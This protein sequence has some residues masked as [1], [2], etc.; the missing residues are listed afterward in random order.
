MKEKIQSSLPDI[1]RSILIDAPIQKVWNAIS[2]TE[3]LALWLMPNDFKL[4][5]DYEFTF[6]SEPKRGWNGIINCKVTEITPPT[7]LAFTWCGNS[8]EQYVSFELEEVEQD[9]TSFLLTHSGWTEENKMIR[10]IMYEGWG[11]LAEDL[12]NKIGEKN[13]KYLS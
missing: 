7:R 11:H 13:A 3:G 10:D 1:Q 9:K 5:M 12:S 4:K 8:L 6:I 2:T